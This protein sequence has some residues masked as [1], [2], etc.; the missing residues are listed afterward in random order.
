MFKKILIPVNP[1]HLEHANTGLELARPLLEEGGEISILLVVEDL[2][3]FLSKEISS[4]AL[5][6]I[7][8]AIKAQLEE[9]LGPQDDDVTILLRGGSAT[10]TIINTQ[11]EDGFDLVIICS[12]RPNEKDYMLGSTAFRVVQRAQCPV[13]VTRQHPSDQGPNND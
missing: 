7:R 6:N 8:V 12:H 11:I 10:G 5:H 9:N 3:E 13:F 2:P 4:E 1:D